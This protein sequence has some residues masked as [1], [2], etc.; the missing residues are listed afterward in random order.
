MR[1]DVIVGFV[2]NL[3]LLVCRLP[4]TL[5]EGERFT[6]VHD[7]GDKDKKRGDAAD[8]GLSYKADV[9]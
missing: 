9:Q 2:A 8:R 5:R 4:F 3:I 1:D 7:S 6:T